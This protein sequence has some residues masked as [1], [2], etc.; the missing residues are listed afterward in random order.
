VKPL[1]LRD[2]GDDVITVRPD[3]R[4]LAESVGLV[5]D[6][7]GE[8]LRADRF[9]DIG[10]LGGGSFRRPGREIEAVDELPVERV[11]EQG[12]AIDRSGGDQ[13]ALP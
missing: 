4:P 8:E 9:G 2:E 7:E 11:Q 5:A 12:K 13:E 10:R 3:S 6:L 1:P